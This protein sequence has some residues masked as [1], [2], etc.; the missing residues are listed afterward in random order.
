MLDSIDLKATKKLMAQART[1]W[2]ELGLELE[3][4]APAA[5]DR[6]HRLE[7]Q[8]IIKGY[9]ALVDPDAL[10]YGLAAFVA[11]SLEKP[12]HR[13]AFLA[14]VQKSPLIQECHHVAGDDDYLLKVRCSGPRQLE[15]LIS[16]ELKAVPGV[17]RTR[18]TV[19]LSTA[20]ETPVVPLQQV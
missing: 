7:K 11:V 18:T 12:E 8:G 6:V 19:V 14:K 3:L 17:S 20:K 13:G 9:H 1:T 10:G 15:W 16:E 5:A 4:S 2:S